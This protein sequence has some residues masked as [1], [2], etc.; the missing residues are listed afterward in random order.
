MQLLLLYYY[1]EEKLYL[2][3][4][5]KLLEKLILKIVIIGFV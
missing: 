2:K 4:F 3:E 1:Y 5:N